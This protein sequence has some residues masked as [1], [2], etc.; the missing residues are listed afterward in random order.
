MTAPMG[1]TVGVLME[2]NLRIAFTRSAL[3]ELIVNPLIFFVGFYAVLHKLISARGI[4]FPQYLPP[5][6]IVQFMAFGAI[7]TAFFVAAD[8]RSGMVNR[9]RTLAVHAAAIVVARLAADVIRVL[10]ILCVLVAAGYTIGFRFQG[11]VVATAGF[12]LVAAGFSLAIAAGAAAI[13][14]GSDNPEA[15]ASM[16][17][18]PLLP[19]LNISTVFVPAHLFPDWLEPVVRVN[20]FSAVADA[21]RSLSG[22]IQA[23]VWPAAV[24]IAGL[25]ALFCLAAAGAFRRERS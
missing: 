20:P 25:T 12:V 9:C 24:W 17:F 19:L 10:V 7:S 22:G 16:V 5:A 13:G 11:G 14:F 21:L 23:P 1:V 3:Q 15:I 18:L 8:R 6:I 4:D 2:R